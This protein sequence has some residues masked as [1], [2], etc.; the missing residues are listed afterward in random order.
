[1]LRCWSEDIKNRQLHN[2]VYSLSLFGEWGNLNAYPSF[3][4]AQIIW[5]SVDTNDFHIDTGLTHS[6]SNVTLAYMCIK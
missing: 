1:C 2:I 4:T 6:A 5:T 3:P